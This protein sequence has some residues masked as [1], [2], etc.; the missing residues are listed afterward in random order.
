MSKPLRDKLRTQLYNYRMFVSANDVS[1]HYKYQRFIEFV[2][3]N[4]SPY[5]PYATGEELRD[6]LPELKAHAAW[7]VYADA[8]TFRNL[9]YYDIYASLLAR[10]E[11]SR[12]AYALSEQHVRVEVTLWTDEFAVRFDPTLPI[13]H[14]N[15]SPARK[16]IHK[17][18]EEERKS[19]FSNRPQ[20]L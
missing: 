14:E 18:Y 4:R 2:M 3:A 6:A 20:P 19:V 12:N 7:M 16:K 1:L 13:M 10:L 9:L 5:P 17:R 11:K 8:S 15:V